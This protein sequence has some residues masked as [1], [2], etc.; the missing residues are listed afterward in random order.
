MNIH[1]S[2]LF[3]VLIVTFL[4]PHFY[5]FANDGVSNSALWIHSNNLITC[6]SVENIDEVNVNGGL[7]IFDYSNSIGIQKGKPWTLVEKGKCYEVDSKP[8]TE[9]YQN[10]ED[11]GELFLFTDPSSEVRSNLL[12]YSKYNLTDSISDIYGQRE[13]GCGQNTNP[14]EEYTYNEDYESCIVKPYKIDVF[15]SGLGYD[16]HNLIK[17]INVS[18]QDLLNSKYNFSDGVTGGTSSYTDDGHAIVNSKEISEVRDIYENL[19]EGV[20]S[21]IQKCDQRI[22]QEIRLK[23][24][25]DY[26]YTDPERTYI[27]R[28]KDGT[29]RELDPSKYWQNST[30]HAN[31]ILENIGCK[32]DVINYLESKNNDI[33]KINKLGE[34]IRLKFSTNPEIGSFVSIK[35]EE[36]KKELADFYKK[37]S[38]GNNIIINSEKIISDNE[39]TELENPT[40]QEKLNIISSDNKMKIYWLLPIIGIVLI[41]GIIFFRKRK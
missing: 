35:S 26:W 24:K 4:F 33:S 22:R 19:A 5:I 10:Y 30:T 40:F 16:R 12:N 25:S 34:D 20:E 8:P 27:S 3:G 9:Q 6:T 14:G 41:L 32:S 13:S 37:S 15:E 38:T 18:I 17:Y 11:L 29:D 1:K 36:Q 2:F 28:Y 23:I 21:V 31:D 7:L 39:K